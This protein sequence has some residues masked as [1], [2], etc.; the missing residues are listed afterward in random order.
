MILSRFPILSSRNFLLPKYGTLQQHSIQRGLL[1]A[2]IDPGGGPLRIYSLHLCHLTAATRLPQVETVLEVLARAPSEGGAWCGGHPEPESG[3][4]EGEMPP[5]P[6]EL[7][8]LGDMNFEPDSAEYARMIGPVSADYGR[9]VNRDGL[10][11][12]WVAAGHGEGEGATHPETGRID[13]CFASA[14][15]AERVVAAW[16]D[17]EARGSDHWPL[18]IELDWPA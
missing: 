14:W 16:V 12:A 3:W 6:R 13:H 17:S 18:W 1:E 2:V 15:L 9:L 5:M 7:L 8:L 10:I 11:D 4:T